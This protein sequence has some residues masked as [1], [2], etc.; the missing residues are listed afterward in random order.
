MTK[1]DL[2]L[3]PNSGTFIG[4]S[5][6]LVLLGWDS[7]RYFSFP[8][9][10]EMVFWGSLTM[11]RMFPRFSRFLAKW[12]LLFSFLGFLGCTEQ[13]LVEK[14]SIENGSLSLKNWDPE[15]GKVLQL[16]GTWEFYWKQLY[17]YE[18][19]LRNKTIL[20]IFGK[21]PSSWTSYSS[22]E[23]PI[24]VDGFATYRLKLI[25]TKNLDYLSLEAFDPTTNYKIFINDKLI[26]ENNS[27]LFDPLNR[28]PTEAS[29]SL[30]EGET[31]LI[32]Q[33]ENRGYVFSGLWQRILIG[34][35]EKI[36]ILHER[37]KIQDTAISGCL[38][39]LGIYHFIF[40]AIRRRDLGLLFFGFF[41]I[42]FS[43]RI[44]TTSEKNF[45]YIFPNIS[46]HSFL[47]LEY[48]ILGFIGPIGLCLLR[49]VFPVDTNRKIFWFLQV[50]AFPFWFGILFMSFPTFVSIFAFLLVS[51][52]LITIY[53]VYVI[54][55]AVF[56]K[57]TGAN[58]QLFG[59]SVLALTVINDIIFSY[60]MIPTGLL[61][62]YGMLFMMICQS[63]VLSKRYAESFD[64]V[65][66]IANH[67][68]KSNL[69]LKELQT[70]LEEKVLE[71]TKEL[72]TAKENAEIA[73]IAKS[74]FLANMSHEIR[75]PLNAVIGF[76]KL[77]F[78]TKMEASQMQY[79]E[80][81]HSSGNSLL[82]LLN[83]ILDFSK[84]EAGKLE[85]SYEVVN[86]FDV[87]ESATNLMRLSIEQKGIQFAVSMD[88]NCPNFIKTDAL[89][90]KQVLVNLLNNATKFTEKGKIELLV[91]VAE[92]SLEK[93][94]IK[95]EFSVVDTGVGIS[96]ENLEKIFEAFSQE[97]TSTTRKYGGT[98]LGLTISNQILRLFGS[99][100][101]LSSKKGEGSR[102]SFF[103][104]SPIIPDQFQ[105]EL[106]PSSQEFRGDSEQKWKPISKNWNVL[107][108]DDV[109]I[110]L[111]LLESFLKKLLPN[112]AFFKA[113]SGEEA[114]QAFAKQKMDFIFMDVQ[115]PNLTGFEATRLIRSMETG[116]QV[117]IIAVT[118]ATVKEEIEK[119]FSSGMSDYLSKPIK[120]E[121][122]HEKILK[123]QDAV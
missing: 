58:V 113:S 36:R 33:V 41:C 38:F 93:D 99:K 35:F 51:I 26:S 49:S 91:N 97:D 76:S 28:F 92:I 122:L 67:L 4:N 30:K 62:P 18:D 48:F 72:E 121:G 83:D 25:S 77:L 107:L 118:A 103:L 90:I 47:K 123:F 110:N 11:V 56:R 79:L 112:S 69:E 22:S 24:S 106:L 3:K 64:Q 82:S 14:V 65:E 6:F 59:Y 115:M 98:G 88:E 44:L 50:N 84:I 80:Y 86:L 45:A 75:T 9:L 94:F 57:R 2:P 34:H 53:A 60:Y 95:L 63:Y 87:V 31:N 66:A 102:F 13:A 70:N 119:C 46:Q 20:P 37:N 89:R 32:I 43:L 8:E 42:L 78:G 21:V 117:P 73:N 120:M 52:F 10:T 1:V 61:A 104:E 71:R 39:M 7:Q 54:L 116:K 27:K 74:Q 15:N 29:F 96:Q 68:E 108:A 40:F 109:E 114:V 12:F 16:N 81:I 5:G 111:I 55:L 101:N 105:K 23:T 100:L 19:F 85:I 17:R